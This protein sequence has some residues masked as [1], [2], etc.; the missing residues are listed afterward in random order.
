LTGEEKAKAGLGIGII[1]FAAI[2]MLIIRSQPNSKVSNESAPAIQTEETAEETKEA[3]IPSSNFDDIKV[4]A[5]FQDFYYD[6]GKQKVVIWIKNES[7]QIFSGKVYV[8]I[9]DGS[10]V[11]YGRDIIYPENLMPG[12]STWAIVWTKPEGQILSYK[13]EG[14]FEGEPKTETTALEIAK[15]YYKSQHDDEITS[16]ES[17]GEVKEGE[18]IIDGNSIYL[19]SGEKIKIN[20]NNYVYVKDGK[21]TLETLTGNDGKEWPLRENPIW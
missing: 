3:E 8:R 17:L 1:I 15:E 5:D 7:S 13:V 21:V 20:K 9:V 14:D 18:K 11:S 6:R 19:L 2:L 16:C 10:D 4:T 12:K